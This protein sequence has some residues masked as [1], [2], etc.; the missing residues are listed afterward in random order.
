MFTDMVGYTALTQ[1]NESLAL[2]VLNR[3][4][5]LARPH[6]QR[7]GGREIKTIGDAFLVEF[8]NA[9]DALECAVDIQTFLHDYNISGPS[10]WKIRLRIGIHLGDVVHSGADILG[11]AVNIAARIEPL[12]EPEGVAISEQV[13]AQVRN[14][15]P[16]PLLRLPPRTMKNVQFPIDVYKVTMPWDPAVSGEGAPAFPR[17]RIAILPFA[18]MSSDPND[19][20]FADGMTEE[21]ISTMSRIGGLRVVARTSVMGYKGGSKKINEIA[22]ELEVG[23]VLEG[24]VRKA[25]SVLRI[26]VQLIDSQTSDHIWS[27]TYDRELKSVFE[28]QSEISRT[29]AEALRIRLLPK[30][31]ELMDRRQEVKPEAF[32]KYLL[33]RQKIRSGEVLASIN[34]LEESV[35]ID[36]SFVLAL[37]ELADAYVL[38]AGDHMPAADA[39]AKAEDCLNRALKLD[40][41]RPEA[42]RSRGDWLFQSR[43]DW[44]GSESAF[45]KSIELNPSYAESYRM[46]SYPLA[47]EGDFQQALEQAKKGVEMDPLSLVTRARLG[48]LYALLERRDEALLECARL[49][50]LHPENVNTRN[51]VALVYAQLGLF[52]KAR[53]EF[54]ELRN[55]MKCRLLKGGRDV[56]IYATWAYYAN[57]FI[58]ARTGE[59]QKVKDMIAE[60]ESPAGGFVGPSSLAALYLALGDFEKGFGLLR[61]GYEKREPSLLF[62]WYLWCYRPFRNE[63]KFAS[64]VKNI[65]LPDSAPTE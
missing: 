38:A 60:A 17:S 36:S 5:L 3:Q 25:G 7:H 2:E 43:W 29:V 59:L 40:D 28:I 61:E 22:K 19:E 6:F 63:E 55:D 50:E 1:S 51:Y 21:L 45:K 20:Y 48:L 33:A 13:Y 53:N 11:D 23:S 64:V 57:A 37:A 12:A 52:Q 27:E 30:E 18:S 31:R 16:L 65:G 56:S 26:A 44:A 41:S 32:D 10:N 54:D 46:V 35:H 9:L 47:A 8:D 24:S 15:S 62:S 49:K 4:N 34:L 58:Y 39:F 42:W 14:K